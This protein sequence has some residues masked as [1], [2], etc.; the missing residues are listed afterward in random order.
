MKPQENVIFSFLFTELFKHEV[1]G[2]DL[3]TKDH[4]QNSNYQCLNLNDDI[5][6]Q[7]AIQELEN[8]V[9]DPHLHSTDSNISKIIQYHDNEV[10]FNAIVFPFLS[11]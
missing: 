10:C 9:D 6:E 1:L 2:H 7:T 5:N 11:I 8:L 3:M 4:L